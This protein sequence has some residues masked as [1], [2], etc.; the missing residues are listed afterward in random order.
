[1]RAGAGRV[2]ATRKTHGAP[3]TMLYIQ[4]HTLVE[5]RA[6]WG[7]GLW[8][9]HEGAESPVAG[10]PEL[11]SQSIRGDWMGCFNKLLGVGAGT[12]TGHAGGTRRDGLTFCGFRWARGTRG[13]AS[14]ALT[15][16]FGSAWCSDPNPPPQ[17]FCLC[18]C[19]SLRNVTSK[20]TKPS[21]CQE[22]LGL[23]LAPPVSNLERYWRCD[24]GGSKNTHFLPVYNQNAKGRT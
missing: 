18:V 10:R 9:Q 16:G 3:Q 8:R 23:S 2:I 20:E 22:G 19:L 1:M 13:E 14:A 12:T 21:I 7:T 5:G 24:V 4:A 6:R 17:R 11:S 15:C